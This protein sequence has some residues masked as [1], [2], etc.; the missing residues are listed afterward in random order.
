MTVSAKVL[1]TVVTT[2]DQKAAMLVDQKATHWVERWVSLSDC[3]A[4]AQSVAQKA[5]EK[6]G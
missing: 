4:V 3:C 2:A 5:A 1:Q 6:A